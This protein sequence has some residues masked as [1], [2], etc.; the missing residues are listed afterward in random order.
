MSLHL[1]CPIPVCVIHC[2][3]ALLVYFV[4]L[5]THVDTELDVWLQARVVVGEDIFL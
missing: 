5:C 3:L 4:L 2:V 1:T